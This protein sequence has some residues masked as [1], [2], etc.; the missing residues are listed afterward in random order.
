MLDTNIQITRDVSLLGMRDDDDWNLQAMF[1]EP[2]RIRNRSCFEIWDNI[3]TLPYK[4]EEPDAVAGIKM[5]YSDLFLNNE[6]LGIFAVG[7]RIDRKQLKLKKYKDGSIRG[8][9]YKGAYWDEA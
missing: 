8:E 1:N 7:E 9:L 5:K 3:Y 2:L 6:Y 4:E